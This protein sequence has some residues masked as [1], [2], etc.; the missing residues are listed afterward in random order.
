MRDHLVAQ[1]ENRTLTIAE[2]ELIHTALS[3]YHEE[4]LV[5]FI[6]DGH[7]KTRILTS[8]ELNLHREREKEMVSWWGRLKFWEK[9][10][11]MTKLLRMTGVIE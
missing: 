8:A 7:Q 10:D 1:L 3:R 11:N 6:V 4:L 9:R 5:R 2:R